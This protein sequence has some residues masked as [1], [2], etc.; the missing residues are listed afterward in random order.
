MARTI[1]RQMGRST[2]GDPSCQYS[3]SPP[4]ASLTP[5]SWRW[6]SLNSLNSSVL[7]EKGDDNIYNIIAFIILPYFH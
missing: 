6:R 1:L 2:R 3:L 7:A 5:L 4:P